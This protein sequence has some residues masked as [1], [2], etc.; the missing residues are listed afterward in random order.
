MIAWQ[1]LR[2]AET[3]AIGYASHVQ[4]EALAAANPRARWLVFWAA[5]LGWMFDGLEMGIFPLVARPALLELMPGADDRFIGQWMGYVTALFLV[6]A[7]AGGLVFGWLGDRFGRVRTMAL[8]G[9]TY[10]IFTGLCFFATHPWQ[11]GALRF[12]AAFGRGGEWWLGVAPVVECW[13][14]TRRPALA[15]G[16]GAASNIGF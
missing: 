5:F 9:L 15:A 1:N 4:F 7:A 2:V 3:E 11:L 16:I 8:S 12:L 10:S 13:P 6:G 14:E